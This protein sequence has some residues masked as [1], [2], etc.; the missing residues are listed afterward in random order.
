MMSFCGGLLHKNG[1]LSRA[2]GNI[3]ELM[4]KSGTSL[5]NIPAASSR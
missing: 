1:L 5:A 2:L 4:K 3:E